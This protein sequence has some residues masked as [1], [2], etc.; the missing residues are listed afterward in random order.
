MPFH[1]S[2]LSFLCFLNDFSIFPKNFCVNTLFGK[3][4]N[5]FTLYWKQLLF[6]LY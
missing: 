3:N 4:E 5:F 6:L 2:F 1:L